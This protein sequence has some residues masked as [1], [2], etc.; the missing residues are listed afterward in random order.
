MIWNGLSLEIL[1]SDRKNKTENSGRLVSKIAQKPL[2]YVGYYLLLF[3]QSLVYTCLKTAALTTMGLYLYMVITA[4]VALISSIH[5]RGERG[6]KS[7]QM[8][9]SYGFY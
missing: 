8:S 5:L 6:R 4:A 3:I 7:Q 2:C 1:T 9:K